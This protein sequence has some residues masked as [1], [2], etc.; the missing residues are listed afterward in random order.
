VKLSE[1]LAK[2][3]IPGILQVRRYHH[4]DGF[5]ADVIH[6]VDLGLPDG[7]E[8]V[9]PLDHTRRR[10]LHPGT[11]GEDLLV[12]VLR[13]GRPVWEAPPLAEVRARAA[14]QLS[15]VHAGVKRLV[16]PHSYPV[17]LERSLYDLRTRLILTAREAATRRIR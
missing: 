9:D 7:P 6:D 4:R 5:L 8:M 16:H 12:P 10:V 1:Q 13:G 11:P 2:T 3:T 14:A 15:R 17:G